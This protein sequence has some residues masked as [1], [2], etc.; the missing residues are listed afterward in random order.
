M[1]TPGCGIFASVAPSQSSIP[2]DAP[3]TTIV[4]RTPGRASAR[5]FA[6]K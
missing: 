5:A 4:W 1:G 2:V 3:G 6:V